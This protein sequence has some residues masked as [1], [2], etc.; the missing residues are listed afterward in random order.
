MREKS[1][2]NVED[3]TNNILD[4]DEEVQVSGSGELRGEFFK[5]RKD[6]KQSG[7]VTANFA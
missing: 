4:D 3:F 7:K 1:S 6:H 2:T 5:V